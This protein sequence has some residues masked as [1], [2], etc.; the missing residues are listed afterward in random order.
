MPKATSSFADMTALGRLSEKWLLISHGIQAHTYVWFSDRSIFSIGAQSVAW[1]L[2]Q[3][4]AEVDPMEGLTSRVAP[5]LD[6]EIELAAGVS[7]R[8]MITAESQAMR[9]FVAQQIHQRSRRAR[10][11]FITTTCDRLLDDPEVLRK[12]AS[13][14]IYCD[15]QETTLSEQQVLLAFVGA[16]YAADVRLITGAPAGLL[17]DV[18]AR[19]FRED[20]YYQLNLIHVVVNR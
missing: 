8:V 4:P 16:S 7:G 12:A 11:P 10:K 19:R 18:Q 3:M 1:T 5:A 6:D 14:T 9:R 15:I 17:Q 20:L 13:G 2:P